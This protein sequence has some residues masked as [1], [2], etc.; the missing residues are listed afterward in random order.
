M[1]DREKDL[2]SFFKIVEIK[3]GEFVFR[4]QNDR[5]FTGLYYYL[6]DTCFAGN[7]FRRNIYSIIY[8]CK[9]DQFLHMM[10]L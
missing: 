4:V 1:F 8:L 5:Y 10:C 7:G 9:I 6:R 3:V 2:Y